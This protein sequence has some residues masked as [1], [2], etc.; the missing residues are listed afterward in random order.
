MGCCNELA[1][2]LE[3]SVFD[4]TRHVNFAK[5]MVLGVD[6]FRQEF[7]YLA[8]RDQWLARDAVGYGTLSGLRV[9]VEASGVRPEVGLRATLRGSRAREARFILR[10]TR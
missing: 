8:G 4:P 10:R 7:A 3:T 2:G 6:D 1:T 9:F 5:G